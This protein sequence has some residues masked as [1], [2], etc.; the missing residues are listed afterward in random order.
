M[1]AREVA[2]AAEADRVRKQQREQKEKE[3]KQ[4]YEAV[5]AALNAEDPKSFILKSLRQVLPPMVVLGSQ[6]E[7]PICLSSSPP[8]IPDCSSPAASSSSE[9]EILD[10]SRPSVRVKKPGRKIESQLRRKAEERRTEEKKH[11]ICKSK[12]QKVPQLKDFLG[13]H[14]NIIEEN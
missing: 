5:L 12:F 4:R 7:I 14:F 13:S 11:G 6:K 9:S 1:T 2:E 10:Q 3:I 8:P